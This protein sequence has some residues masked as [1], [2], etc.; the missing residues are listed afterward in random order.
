MEKN[1][2]LHA[3]ALAALRVHVTS[4]TQA[5]STLPQPPTRLSKIAEASPGS[6]ELDAEAGKASSF[7]LKKTP[8]AVTAIGASE[9]A[10]SHAVDEPKLRRHY[11]QTSG[12]S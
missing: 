10:F 6:Q 1:A 3:L 2:R 4:F 9:C 11:A 5:A 8:F 7:A 12:L